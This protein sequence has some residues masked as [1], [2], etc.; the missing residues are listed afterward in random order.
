M[1]MTES[2]IPSLVI[3]IAGSIGGL[4]T[5]RVKALTEQLRAVEERLRED[6]RSVYAKII[7]PFAKLLS[8]SSD[9]TKRS[10]VI[11]HLVLS[12]AF[13]RIRLVNFEYARSG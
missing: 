3:V 12:C 7:F 4:V 8:P 2:L 6:R 5:W 9:E 10:E 1:D 11:E 13:A